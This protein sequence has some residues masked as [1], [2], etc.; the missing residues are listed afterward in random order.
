MSTMRQ[1]AIRS[2]ACAKHQLNRVDFKTIHIKDLFGV[3][4]FNEEVQRQRLPKQVFKALQKT[5]RQ[6]APLDPTVAGAIVTAAASN[7]DEKLFDA[8]AAAADKAV[9]PEEQYRYLY[10]LGDFRD[11]ALIDRGL[12]RSL[13][14][15]LKSQDTALYLVQFFVNPHARDRAWTFVIANWTALEPKVAI[16]GGDT[17]LVRSLGAFC[18]AGARDRITTFFA[19]HPLPAA[20]RTLSQTVEQTIGAQRATRLP[21][22][23]PR[24]LPNALRC[25]T[26]CGIGCSV[27]LRLR[28]RRG[29]RRV[30]RRWHRL[31]LHRAGVPRS[32]RPLRHRPQS[33]RPTREHL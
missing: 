27:A 6:G 2:I 9:S 29:D 15:Q 26:S 3:N 20:A 4:V 33:I 16:Y 21:C 22:T 19:A 28:G 11:P 31:V 13:S 8:L 18:D 17:N 10:A 1:E 24:D 23:H 25:V 12:Q 7:G 14:P 32:K 5:I 30:R